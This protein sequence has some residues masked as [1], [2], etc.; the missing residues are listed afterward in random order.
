MAEIGKFHI[1]TTDTNLCHEVTI[2]EDMRVDVNTNTFRGHLRKYLQLI[3]ILFFKK[4]KTSKENYQQTLTGEIL[5]MLD[6]YNQALIKE[7]LEPQ[8]I[9]K[10][11]KKLEV[12]NK[13]KRVIKKKTK[14]QKQKLT[15]KKK[16]EQEYKQTPNYIG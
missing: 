12:M 11:L 4:I 14:K 6:N 1:K 15:E 16:R 2:H 10:L 7:G 13:P 9:Q 8:N 5:I 3:K